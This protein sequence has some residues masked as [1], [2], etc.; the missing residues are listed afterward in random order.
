MVMVV[1]DIVV[2]VEMVVV[3]VKGIHVRIVTVVAFV[4]VLIDWGDWWSECCLFDRK[5]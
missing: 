4:K 5:R 1:W 3:V 2:E